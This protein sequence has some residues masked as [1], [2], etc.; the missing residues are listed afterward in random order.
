MNEQEKFLKELENDGTADI[1]TKPLDP[2]KEPEGEGEKA[3]EVVAKPK[4]GEDDNEGRPRNRRERRLTAKLQAERESSMFMAGRL[5]AIAEAQKAKAES[6]GDYLKNIERIYGTDS[7]E[8]MAATELLKE[9]LKS[10][11]ES[12][13]K[14]ALEAFKE[15]QRQA[16]EAVKKE[17]EALDMMLEELE[18][19][20]NIDLTSDSAE[21]TRKGFFK[22]LQKMSPK[23][24]EGNIVAYADH[25]AVWE[26]YKT[27]VKKPENRAKDLSSRSMVESGASKDSKLEDD[28]S[29]RFL[30]EHGII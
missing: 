16:N 11:K 9:A 2:E 23:D 4:E 14:D 25:H 24:K 7:P 22:L 3:P 1:L 26:Q 27:G 12:A 29:T 18:D 10:V 20:H 17:E 5:E 8:A 19:E 13:T 15:E 28:A 30:K 6:G 21:S